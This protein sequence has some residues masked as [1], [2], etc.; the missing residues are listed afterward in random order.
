M[1]PKNKIVYSLGVAFLLIL[2]SY[3]LY[4][5]TVESKK[6]NSSGLETLDKSV[7]VL[8]FENISNDPEQEYFVTG[9]MDEVINHLVKVKVFKGYSSLNRNDLSRFK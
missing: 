6:L 5:R 4:N 3:L 9:M 1:P 2:S 7:V 8:P